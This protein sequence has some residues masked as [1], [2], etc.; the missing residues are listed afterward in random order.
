MVMIDDNGND[1]EMIIYVIVTIISII[2]HASSWRES[3]V[4]FRCGALVIYY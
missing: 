1:S 3:E 4:Q 2:T